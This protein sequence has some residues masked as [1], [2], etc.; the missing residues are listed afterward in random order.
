MRLRRFVSFIRKCYTYPT[1]LRIKA[2]NTHPDRFIPLH[3]PAMSPPSPRAALAC[4]G[5]AVL[6]TVLVVCLL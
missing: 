4:I 5:L 6:A 3:G 1:P 2:M